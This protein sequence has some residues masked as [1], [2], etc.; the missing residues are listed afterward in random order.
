MK[1]YFGMGW[2]SSVLEIVSFKKIKC[3]FF[4]SLKISK[5]RVDTGYWIDLKRESFPGKR[6]PKLV[7]KP[8]IN[9]KINK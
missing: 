5:Y 3:V 2:P 6:V 8:Y 4:Q 7:P 9:K 1:K